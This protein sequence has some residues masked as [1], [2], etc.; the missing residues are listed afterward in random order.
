MLIYKHFRF[1][2]K[3]A[4]WIVPA[5][6][7]TA[8]FEAWGAAGGISSPLSWAGKPGQVTGGAGAPNTGFDTYPPHDSALGLAYANNAGYAKGT[9]NVS[10]G[11]VYYVA[12]GGNGGPGFSSIKRGLN[13]TSYSVSVRGGVG[14]WNGGGA[15]GKGAHMYQNLFNSTSGY[16]RYTQSTIPA[17]A[18]SGQVWYDTAS[19]LVYT[20]NHTYSSGASM[21]YWTKT[22]DSHE[23]GV[24]SS[25]GGGGG[26]TDFRLSTD[27]DNPLCILIA[28]GGGGSGGSPHPT[29]PN[30]TTLVATPK[31]P[32]PPFGSDTLNT[33]ATGTDSTWASTVNY[34][35]GGWGTGGLGGSTSDA[36]PGSPTLNGGTATFG[37]AGGPATARHA[38]GTFPL[39][40]PGSGGYGGQNDAGG[41]RGA[42]GQNATAGTA[43]QGGQGADADGGYDDWCC[44]G[45]GGG[46]GEYGGGGGGQGFMVGGNDACGGGGGGGANF[47]SSDMAGVVLT[48]LARPPA[49]TGKGTGAN[50]LGGFA[51]I[52][53]R[54]PPTVAWVSVPWA[55]QGGTQFTVAFS[56]AP[57]EAGGTGISHYVVGTGAAGDS[58]PG[59]QTTVMV[60]DPTQTQF[61]YTFTAPASGATEAVFVQ[62]VDLDG[63]ASAWLS[64]TVTGLSAAATTGATITSPAPGSQFVASATP[65]WTLGTQTPLVTYRLGL[66]GTSLVDGSVVNDSTP[67]RRGGSRVNL[68]TDPGFTGSVVWS[69]NENAKLVSSSANPGVSG[70]NGRIN[71]TL[72]NGFDAEQHTTVWNN[73]LPGV[74]YHLHLNVSSPLAN[75]PRKYAVQVY[76]KDGLLLSVNVDLSTQAANAYKTVD[77]IFTPRT[78][79]V[80]LVLVPSAMAKTGAAIVSYDFE[81]GTAGPFTALSGATVINDGFFFQ[82]GSRA[83]KVTS[84]SSAA[85]STLNLATL[86]STAGTYVLEASVYS[87]ASS[88]QNPTLTLGSTTVSSTTRG[89]WVPFRLPFTWDGSSAVN[90]SLYGNTGSQWYDD[91]SITAT[92]PNGIADFGNT[93]SGQITD[94]A[95]L[96]IEP[97]GAE[98]ASGYLPYFDS[99]HLNGNTGTVSVGTAGT[100][101]LT[102]TDV[103]S[104]TLTYSGP[105]LNNGSLYLE[106]RTASAV[107]TGYEGA[108][109]QIAVAVNPSLPAVP[110]VTMEVNSSAGLITLTINAND[111]G[112]THPT[113]SFDILRDGLRIATGLTPDDTTRLATFVDTPATKT[114]A[115]YTVRAFDA[116]GGYADQTDGTVTEVG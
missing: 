34:L 76:D 5:G 13:G 104:G 115:T 114:A 85:A 69:S 52:T 90:L 102:G 71:W 41:G 46:G 1:T 67:W 113:V 109:T 23:H 103:T 84:S 4:S 75:D 88:A 28:G 86:L 16:A 11:Q 107:A 70:K 83:L 6:V 51:R 15:G 50:G 54:R 33:G 80:Y 3:F 45:G 79:G 111:A 22:T 12:V 93:D 25:G 29:G 38:A 65:H 32:N 35:K 72:T 36:P 60:S 105:P 98:D 61:W 42:G 56:F 37:G 49:D 95:N 91:I 73:L 7:S 97:S 40:V 57:A 96:M 58:F 87:P 94:L 99:S 9:R 101:I 8:T 47:A 92:D 24:G 43:H 21:S 10:T 44:G 110:T 74:P 68:A 2:G 18:T 89:A 81:N 116:Q 63:D 108:T 55:V 77:A 53:Y 19:H 66:I 27:P 59:T 48:G 112:A 31:T 62:A 26:Q 30:L 17:A 106:T 100:S 64:S 39:P 82:S 20:C 78:Q 14:G